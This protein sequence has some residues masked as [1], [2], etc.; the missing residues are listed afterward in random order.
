MTLLRTLHRPWIAPRHLSAV[1]PGIHEQGTLSADD[2][3]IVERLQR[4]LNAQGYECEPRF[5]AEP[6]M[7][8]VQLAICL[9]FAGFIGFL[10]AVGGL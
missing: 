2:R 10:L 4:Y 8:W 3:E 7:P 5:R 1:N 6:D 9:L